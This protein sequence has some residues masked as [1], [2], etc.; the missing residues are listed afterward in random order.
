[1]SQVE[2]KIKSGTQFA[3]PP[4]FRIIY[5][6]DDKTAAEFVMTSLIEFF[7]YTAEKAEETTWNIHEH[8][9]AIVAVM[10]Y[11]IAEQKGIEVTV[12][13]RKEGYPLQVKLEPETV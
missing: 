5:L 3:E 2:T 4:L 1:M 9:S 6:N 13:A 11:E 8:G 12:S 10:P 7:N